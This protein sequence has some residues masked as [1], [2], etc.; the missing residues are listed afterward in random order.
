MIAGSFFDKKEAKNLLSELKKNNIDGFIWTQKT[1]ENDILYRVQVGALITEEE[2]EI[3]KNWLGK[4]GFKGII[5][6]R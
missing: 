5:L 2:A 3:C 1:P 6:K 4:K